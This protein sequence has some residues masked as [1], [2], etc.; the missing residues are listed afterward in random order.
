MNKKIIAGLVAAATL[1]LS[2]MA[3]A[4]IESGKLVIWVNGDKAYDG[5]A[6]V[7]K[8]FTAD[9]GVPVEVAHPDAVEN[10][11]QQA[12]ST[13]NGPDI[14][15]WAHDRFGEWAKAGLLTELSPSKGVQ[16]KFQKFAW[17]AL[18]IDGKIYG[19]PMSVEA[20]GLICNSD[21]VKTA[22]ANF[23][24]FAALEKELSAKGKHAIMWD[25]TGPYFTY[26][27]IAAN[28]G[29]VFK[30]TGPGLYDVKDTGIANAGAKQ[31]VQ[32]LYDMIKNKVM[33]KGVDYGVMDAAFAKGDVACIIN[34]PWS[35]SNYDQKIKYT[36]NPLPK[37]AGKPAKAFV[38]VQG[39]AIN[40]QS[41]NKELAVAFIEDYLLT[42]AGLKVVNDDK[43]LGAAAL[44]SFQKTLEKDPRIKA[45]MANAVNGEPMPNVPE[46]NRFWS[47]FQQALKNA[48][49][50]RQTVDEALATAASRITQ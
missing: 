48:T 17:D 35:W 5:I 18:T 44:K 16:D 32:F 6:A 34:G 43:A 50:N 23:E 45:T 3:S 14:F 20:I 8:K 2:S 41:P 11:F 21:I 7:G 28:G 15:M 22:P 37:L 42:D 31:G 36:V 13:G 25:Y 47:A 12:A 46:M 19:Y 30:K 26:P 24:D 4:G 49:T 1:G 39:L 27:L 40:A 10:K 38:G 29:Y 9:Q 33:E